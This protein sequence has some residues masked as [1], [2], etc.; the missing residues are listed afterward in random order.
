MLTSVRLPRKVNARNSSI[1]AHSS[2]PRLACHLLFHSLMSRVSLTFPLGLPGFEQERSFALVED[3][4]HAPLLLLE[5]E[6][7]P[8]LCFHA[9]PVA[10][11]DPA[12]EL[13]LSAEDLA[14]LCVEQV[15]CEDRVL[16]LVILA[17]AKNSPLTAN[18]LAPVVVNYTRGLGVQAVRMDQRY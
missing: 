3:A 8:D 14:V 18:M 2:P 7:T 13:H 11:V 1:P 9:L 16:C 10:A 4:S 15:P 17:A 5:S 6:D 12:Y